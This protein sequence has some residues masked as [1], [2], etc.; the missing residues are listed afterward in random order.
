[1]I[2]AFPPR[3]MVSLMYAFLNR[4]FTQGVLSSVNIYIFLQKI[5]ILYNIMSLKNTNYIKYIRY[6]CIKY[7]KKI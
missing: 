5:Y 3:F 4:P 7:I 2:Y 6:K 1:M